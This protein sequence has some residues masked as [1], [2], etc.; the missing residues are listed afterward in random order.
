VRDRQ[1][2]FGKGKEGVYEVD[3]DCLKE[4]AAGI[5]KLTPKE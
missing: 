3:A 5:A 2:Y 4:P 1:R